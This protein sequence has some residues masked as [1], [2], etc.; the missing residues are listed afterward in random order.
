MPI[1][2]ERAI[3]LSSRP[4]YTRKSSPCAFSRKSPARASQQIDNS[5]KRL[6][7]DLIENPDIMCIVSWGLQTTNK[8]MLE[9]SGVFHLFTF[10]LL[11]A[12]A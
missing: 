11:Q 8:I 1:L 2:P 5:E 6:P 7:T 9:S 3:D 10:N 4:P 12:F